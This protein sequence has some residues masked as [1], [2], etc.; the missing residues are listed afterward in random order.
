[1][2]RLKNIVIR[3]ASDILQIMRSVAVNRSKII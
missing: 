1:M 2:L 3:P